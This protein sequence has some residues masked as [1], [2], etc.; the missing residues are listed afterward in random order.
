MGAEQRTEGQ[1]VGLIQGQRGP[2]GVSRCTVFPYLCGLVYILEG[3]GCTTASRS[4]SSAPSSLG[5]SETKP[6]FFSLGY[7]SAPPFRNGPHCEGM[8][9]GHSEHPG[10]TGSAVRLC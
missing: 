5:I 8:G 9:R 1:A 7:T 6:F 10:V 3:V 4:Q 2:W